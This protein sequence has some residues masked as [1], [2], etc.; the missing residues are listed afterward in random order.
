MSPLLPV[1]LEKMYKYKSDVKFT[2]K[3]LIQ[4]YQVKL[5]TLRLVDKQL[6]PKEFKRI[7]PDRVIDR[8]ENTLKDFDQT[9]YKIE[10]VDIA[11]HLL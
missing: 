9:A 3:E 11:K 7:V 4:L 1:L 10:Q 6:L 2:E 8:A 5:H